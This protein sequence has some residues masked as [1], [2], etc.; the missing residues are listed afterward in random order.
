M[1]LDHMTILCHA[2]IIG[3]TKGLSTPK[4]GSTYYVNRI[5][6]LSIESSKESSLSNL[7]CSLQHLTA[8]IKVQL[9]LTCHLD[10]KTISTQ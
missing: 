1:Y 2:R 9:G 8:V 7:S 5:S 6:N 3:I 4:G 10:L